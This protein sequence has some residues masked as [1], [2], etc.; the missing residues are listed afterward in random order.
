MPKLALKFQKSCKFLNSCIF[1]KYLEL[2]KKIVEKSCTVE[3]LA[4]RPDYPRVAPITAPTLKTKN[5]PRRVEVFLLKTR[6]LPRS[7]MIGADP[8]LSHRLSSHRSRVGKGRTGGA[9]HKRQFVHRF[10]ITCTPWELTRYP[11]TYLLFYFYHKS[12]CKQMIHRT[13]FSS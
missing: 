7:S 2:Q 9:P 10:E 12:P 13:L 5:P 11:H 6:G 1:K 8:Y 3:A 4:G